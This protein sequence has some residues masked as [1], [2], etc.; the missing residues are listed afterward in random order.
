MMRVSSTASTLLLC[1]SIC[2]YPLV[3]GESVSENVNTTTEYF[4][5]NFCLA[6]SKGPGR[7]KNSEGFTSLLRSVIRCSSVR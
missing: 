3:F 5:S 4:I 1:I 6:Q 7:E 2:L